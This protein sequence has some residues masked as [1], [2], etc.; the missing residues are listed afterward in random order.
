METYD[1]F[2]KW[3]YQERALAKQQASFWEKRLKEFESAID[4][5]AEA[6][7]QH[8]KKRG[9]IAVT[10]GSSSPK[11]KVGVRSCRLTTP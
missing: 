2:L 4:N 11:R 9:K 5:M 3:Y 7:H 6:K 8:E 1:D 10:G